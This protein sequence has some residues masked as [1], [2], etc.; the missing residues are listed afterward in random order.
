MERRKATENTDREIVIKRV[1]NSPCKTLWK[2]WS[3]PEV[4]KRWWA[5]EGCTTPFCHVEFRVGGKLHYCMRMADGKDIWGLGIYREIIPHV[6]LVFTDSFADEKGNLVAPSHY[7][8]SE[9][10]GLETVV[11]VI[12][13]ESGGKTELTLKQTVNRSVP[14]REGMMEGWS[15]MFNRLARELEAIR[16]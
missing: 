1:F 5:P 12:F 4:L 14:E 3:D 8:M 6:R 10:L 9:D 13:R 16:S 7:G 2:A 15:Q 11:T